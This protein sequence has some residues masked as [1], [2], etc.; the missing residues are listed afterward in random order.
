MLHIVEDEDHIRE[1]LTGIAQF[2]GLE[3]KLFYSADSYLKYLK[4]HDYIPPKALITDIYLPG[5]IG[6]TICNPL[7]SKYPDVSFVVMSGFLEQCNIRCCKRH[8]A[9][10]LI[11]HSLQKPFK[12]EQLIELLEAIR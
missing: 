12:M 3:T 9:D 11:D 6:C 7:K 1:M 10:G 8:R 5:L 4:S 2:V